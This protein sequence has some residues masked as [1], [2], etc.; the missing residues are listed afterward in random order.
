MANDSKD[1][2]APLM[3]SADVA[4]YLQVSEGTVKQWVHRR[5]LPFVKVGRLNRFRR[6]DI[7]AW[8]ND[9]KPGEAA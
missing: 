1:A 3:T 2:Q 6:E 7:D 9:G 4:A 5:I 8:V